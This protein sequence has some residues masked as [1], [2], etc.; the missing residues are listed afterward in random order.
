MVAHAFEVLGDEQQMR[1][2]AG[3]TAVDWAWLIGTGPVT[4]GSLLLFA[5]G[6]P[7]PLSPFRCWAGPLI[8]R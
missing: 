3:Q 1:D 2:L 6:S 5:A 7:S 4:A 8:C